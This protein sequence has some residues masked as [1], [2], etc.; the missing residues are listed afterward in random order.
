MKPNRLSKEKSPYLLQHAYNP[1]VPIEFSQL[2]K[3][4]TIGD[5]EVNTIANK[6]LSKYMKAFEKLA[7]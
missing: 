3:E 5:E 6:V 2:Q 1:N 7:K 4:E